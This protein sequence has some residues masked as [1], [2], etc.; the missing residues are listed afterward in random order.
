MF[1]LNKT[2]YINNDIKLFI[3][4]LLKKLKIK[5]KL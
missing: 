4:Y 5:I 2:K 1:K 3:K